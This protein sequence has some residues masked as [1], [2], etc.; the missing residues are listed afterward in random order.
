MKEKEI[1]QVKEKI[2]NLYDNLSFNLNENEK[3]ADIKYY[4]ELDI[5]PQEGSK[6]GL[7]EN[8][9]LV[10]REIVKEKEETK[11]IYELYLEDGQKVAEISENGEIIFDEAYIQLLKERFKELYYKIGIEERKINVKEL[12]EKSEE[13]ETL[14]MLEEEIIENKKEQE[15][16]EESKEQLEDEENKEEELEDENTEEL[17]EV[18]KATGMQEKDVRACTK[19]NPAEKITDTESFYDIVPSTKKYEKIFVVASS[20]DTKGNSKFHFVG[21]TKDGEAEQIE[22]LEQTEGVNTSKEVISIN[23]DGSEVKEKQVSALFKVGNY[24]KGFSVSI[25]DYG[26]IEAEYIR[27][28]PENKYIG[29]NINTT[30]QKPTIKE[31]KEFMSDTRNPYMQNNVDKAEEQIEEM[32]SEKTNIRNIDDNENNDVVV[33]VDEEIKLDNGNITTIRKEAEKLGIELEEYVRRCEEVQADTIEEKI[34]QVNDEIEEE[35]RQE[36][37]NEIDEDDGQRTPWG[38]AYNRMMKNL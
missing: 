2:S 19:I 37:Q 35:R 6:M 33:D 5:V 28:T 7:S 10:K 26:V 32:E 30:T 21:V 9:Y 27:R 31:V 16:K 24:N 17:K 1:E 22:E 13:K 4:R 20:K 29:S 25:G 38:D 12:F 8:I 18:A 34:E 36:T 3:V 15:E 11:E 14:E 23:R